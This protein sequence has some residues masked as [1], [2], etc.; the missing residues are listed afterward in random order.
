LP[1]VGSPLKPAARGGYVARK[2]LPADIRDAY[3]KLYGDG[4]PQWE[5]WFNS[6]SVSLLQAKAKHRDWLTDVEAKIANIRAERRGNGHML[7]PQGARALAGEWYHW[8][9]A[10]MAANNWPKEVLS[11]Y[12]D[13]MWRGF[14][15]LA[16]GFDDPFAHDDLAKAR[17]GISDE[18]K[19]AQFL[20]AKNLALDPPSRDMF[21][22][23][24]ARDF[25]AALD[26][27]LRRA[28]GDYRDDYS[29]QFP[30]QGILDSDL[31]PWSL[32][33]QWIA[34]ATPA[35]A[36]VDRWRATFLKLQADFPHTSAAALLPEQALRWAEGLV[37][38][39]RS[40]VTVRD[41]WV[42]ACRAVY[43]WAIG[44]KLVNR[45]PF[46]GWRIKVPKKIR[47]RE[48]KAFTKDEIATILKAAMNVEVRSK[49]DAGKRWV[50]WLAAYTGAR[51]GELTQLRGSDVFEQD[52]IWAV[53][54]SPE[55]G[56]VKT[57]NARSVPL[58]E[59]LIKQGFVRFAKA[60][61]KG[62]LFYNEAK[63][64]SGTD[65]TNPKRP[66]AVKARERIAAWV[67]K[68]GV[69]DPELRPNH[70]WRHTFKKIGDRAGLSEKMLDTICG[71]TQV[72]EGR[73]YGEADLA[74]KAEALSRFPRFNI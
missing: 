33:E 22:D 2:S 13:R 54:I 20:A 51:V 24:V 11:A 21:L 39:E 70:A 44:K 5:A 19:T 55:S 17:P 32:F 67:R 47:T 52:G 69:T 25:F 27:L 56:T 64:T 30:K 1:K 26:L 15:N 16:E 43:A 4:R 10:H 36:T 29:E 58:H 23:Y 45:N 63:E 12:R 61:G 41:V 31:T 57:G 18:G 72:S 37:T 6:G 66:R 9:V 46:T 8:F 42:I 65:P 62:A 3:G 60:S 35:T 71:H 53:K 50:P 34:E 48:T 73:K 14:C 7:T 59:H 38:K 28:A 40:A 74:D 68:I 49:M